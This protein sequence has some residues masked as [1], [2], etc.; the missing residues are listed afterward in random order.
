[1]PGK[2]LVCNANIHLMTV[3]LLGHVVFVKVSK[4]VL[5][6][7]VMRSPLHPNSSVITINL[8]KAYNKEQQ[9][10]YVAWSLSVDA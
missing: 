3:Y 8:Q 10:W 2:L 6:Y 5:G 7:G 1:M 9:A 4:H